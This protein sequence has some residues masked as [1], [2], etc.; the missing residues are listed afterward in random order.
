MQVIEEVPYMPGWFVMS[1]VGSGFENSVEATNFFY[2]SGLCEDVDPL[3][4]FDFRPS[5][6]NDP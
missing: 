4:M 6:V 5:S 1:I 2:E 3:F